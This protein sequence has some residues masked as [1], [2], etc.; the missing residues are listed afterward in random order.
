VFFQFTQHFW[1]SLF[2]KSFF[3]TKNPHQSASPFGALSTGQNPQD[4]IRRM[5][6]ALGLPRA[7]PLGF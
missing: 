2:E 3:P 7:V 4:E 6:L 1:A 5:M